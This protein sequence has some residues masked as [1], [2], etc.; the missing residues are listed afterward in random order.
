MVHLTIW[1]Q[2]Y[3]V[4]PLKKWWF[5]IVFCM[6][7]RGYVMISMQNRSGMIR[8][9]RQG[10]QSGSELGCTTS[11]S[12][13]YSSWRSLSM[14][15]FHTLRFFVLGCFIFTLLAFV[16]YV[17]QFGNG[18]VRWLKSRG[19]MAR[20]FHPSGRAI[21]PFPR[22]QNSAQWQPLREKKLVGNQVE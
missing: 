20:W 9:S 1:P 6:F 2:K 12:A 10:S 19:P 5:S 4:F 7:T 13:P 15:W 14:E 18:H 3:W 22:W 8:V 17:L 21:G 16:D 11:T